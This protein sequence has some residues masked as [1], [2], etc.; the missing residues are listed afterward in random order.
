[1]AK[2]LKPLVGEAAVQKRR[3]AEEDQRLDDSVVY[4]PPGHRLAGQLTTHGITKFKAMAD[5]ALDEQLEKSTRIFEETGIEAGERQD[6]L[7]RRGVVTEGERRQTE[8]K[9]LN[10]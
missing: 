4:F 1:M 6:V 8:R 5:D 10:K 7:F 3:Q 9:K 2:K